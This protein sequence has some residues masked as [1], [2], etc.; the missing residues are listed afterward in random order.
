MICEVCREEPSVGVFAIPYVPMSVRYGEKCLNANAH[1]WEI[2]VANTACIGGRINSN[3]EWQKM[4]VCT[5]DHLNR[6][7][8]EFDLC[9]DISIKEMNSMMNYYDDI[10]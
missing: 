9:V 2:L 6:T 10:E 1:P 7:L 4:I 3:E 5:C 8:Q